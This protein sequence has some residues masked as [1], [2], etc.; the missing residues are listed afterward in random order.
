[1]NTNQIEKKI[2]KKFMTYPETKNYYFEDMPVFTKWREVK[3]WN[4]CIECG[5]KTSFYYDKIGLG[6]KGYIKKRFFKDTNYYMGKTLQK[7]LQ[8]MI[9]DN[10]LSR[11]KLIEKWK[12]DN[13]FINGKKSL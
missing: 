11:N 2:H 9:E 6:L 4:E 3:K 7:V 12:A 8:P 1:M 13:D 10:I 5:H